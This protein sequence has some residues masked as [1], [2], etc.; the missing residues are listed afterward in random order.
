MSLLA[1]LVVALTAAIAGGLGVSLIRQTS[2]Q[3]ARQQLSKVADEAQSDIADGS[4]AR[5]RLGL[6]ALKINI[7]TIGRAGVVVSA[8]LPV[9]HALTRKEISKILAGSEVSASRVVDGQAMLIEA[10][11]TSTGG[12]VLVER[13][14]DAVA[15][16]DRAIRRLVLALVVAGV[17]AALLA[18]PADRFGGARDGGGQT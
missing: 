9:Q 18:S 8:N 15:V 7:G 12:V 5:T 13:R 4:A 10:R 11:P 16:G 14:S 17:I 2:G 6:A 3:A 1:V